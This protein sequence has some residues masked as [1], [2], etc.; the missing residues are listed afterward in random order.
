MERTEDVFT[1]FPRDA[2]SI[3]IDC[4]DQPIR[5]SVALDAQRLAVSGCVGDDVQ[6][7]APERTAF[8]DNEWIAVEG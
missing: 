2:R 5:G 4:N 7:T 8:D 6:Q 3:I 1:L